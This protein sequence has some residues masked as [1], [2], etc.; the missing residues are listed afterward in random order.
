MNIKIH[1]EYATK[2]RTIKP[3]F[4]RSF[5][6]FGQLDRREEN[7][8]NTLL[9]KN[10]V[11]VEPKRINR[12]ILMRNPKRIKYRQIPRRNS[13]DTGKKCNKHIKIYTD[14]AKKRRK[15]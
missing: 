13:K 3:I 8:N 7:R 15:S 14:R 2:P 12:P 11:G 9:F 5:E 4:I 6:Y 1:D 10:S